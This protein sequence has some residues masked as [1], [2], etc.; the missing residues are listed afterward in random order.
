[1]VWNKKKKGRNGRRNDKPQHPTALVT[2]PAAV[3]PA[4]TAPAVAAAPA[5]SLG[6]STT[7]GV[8]GL[9]VGLVSST[10][11]VPR[12]SLG[13]GGGT[14]I[15]SGNNTVV[16][17]AGSSNQEIDRL[18]QEL[19]RLQKQDELNNH[20]Y[21]KKL[22]EIQGRSNGPQQNSH[23]SH[24][25]HAAAA[26]TA[27]LRMKAK[28]KS[29][30]GGAPPVALAER[31]ATGRRSEGDAP[32]AHQRPPVVAPRLPAAAIRKAP[33]PAERPATAPLVAAAIKKAPALAKR[34]A[35][36]GTSEGNAPALSDVGSTE[37]STSNVVET[38][39]RYNPIAK[40]DDES[41]TFS[42]YGREVPTKIFTQA[43]NRGYGEIINTYGTGIPVGMAEDY[44]TTHKG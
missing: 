5:C 23:G 38:I 33:A 35:T 9:A 30:V 4:V 3:A 44:F 19:D 27:R 21:A 37:I 12:P 15:G 34:S 36:G 16:G 6:N 31:S 1:M 41:N 8:G 22:K 32:A 20:K 18:Q 24:G 11:P 13:V 7:T 39:L 10:P 14:I 26:V 25:P 2:V 28:K 40:P 29:Q 17:T 42:M 43:R